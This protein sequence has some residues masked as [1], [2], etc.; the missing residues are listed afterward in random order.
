MHICSIDPGIKNFAICI[1]NI[2]T[3]KLKEITCPDNRFIKQTAK[4]SI[5]TQEYCEF[6][7]KI[8]FYSNTILCENVDISMGVK[9][10]N[11]KDLSDKILLNLKEY[12]ESKKN[13]FDNCEVIIIEK[14]MCF[15]GKINHMAIKIAY[16]CY[17]WFLIN[18]GE[19][20]KLVDFMAYNKTQIMGAPNNLTKVLRKK[21]SSNKCSEIWNERNDTVMIEK[22]KKIKKKDDL[23]DTLLM[24]LAYIIINFFK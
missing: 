22:L 23:G 16:F 4:I 13:I 8:I 18:Y 24:C 15:K 9:M 11:S 19:N 10:R 6:L 21:W 2:D 12:L 7:K 14:Q 20:K 17:S 1:E 5:P 3:N